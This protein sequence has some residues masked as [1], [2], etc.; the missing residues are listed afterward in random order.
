MRSDY[1]REQ[2]QSVVLKHSC[3][4]IRGNS[5]KPGSP[6]QSLALGCL[7]YRRTVVL[8]IRCAGEPT[9]SCMCFELA[10]K[11]YLSEHG[12][13]VIYESFVPVNGES[14]GICKP[15]E[16]MAV[17]RPPGLLTLDQDFLI[18]YIGTPSCC[19]TLLVLK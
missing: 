1:R 2:S 7:E 4:G 14:G 12:S 3:H 5:S 17:H 6:A 19:M 15:P 11:M 18:W 9:C 13:V 10:N 8:M 16:P